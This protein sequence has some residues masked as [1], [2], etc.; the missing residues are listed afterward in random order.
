MVLQHFV[1]VPPALAKLRE[2][3][4]AG[5]DLV[6]R[7]QKSLDLAA[8]TG[9]CLAFACP[10]SSPASAYSQMYRPDS[11][12]PTYTCIM[13][14]FALAGKFGGLGEPG[15]LSGGLP[16]PVPAPGAIAAN[17][18]DPMPFQQRES[19]SRRVR[20]LP[21]KSNCLSDIIELIGVE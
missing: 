20:G 3:K 9:Q 10:P 7:L 15:I 13:Q 11:R 18:N 16:P 5:K 2:F 14:R 21:A 12:L 6:I 8:D 17:A 4:G 1:H 19:H